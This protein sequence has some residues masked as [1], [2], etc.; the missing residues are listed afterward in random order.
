M[1]MRT[2]RICI[3]E[4]NLPSTSGPQSIALAAL[5]SAAVAQGHRVITLIAGDSETVRHYDGEEP[6]D[7]P[8]SETTLA[9]PAISG[10]RTMRASYRTYQWLSERHFDLIFAGAHQSPL[11]YSLL[12]KRQGTDFRT[13]AF[14]TVVT[15]LTAAELSSEGRFLDGIEHLIADEIERAVIER[16]DAVI[17]ADAD[18][19]DWIRGQDWPRPATFLRA[20][21]AGDS[22]EAAQEWSEL[23]RR[24]IAGV[25]EHSDEHGDPIATRDRKPLVSACIVSFNRHRLLS[26]AIQSI[27]D[28]TY[29]N[30]EIIVVDDASDAPE[31]AIQLDRIAVE[32]EGCGGRLIRHERNRYLGAARN[33][34]ARHATGEY[35]F[36]LDDD[37]IAKPDQI[38]TLVDVA[39]FTNCDIVNSFC[40]RHFGEDRPAPD[41]GSPERWIMLGNVPSVGLFHNLFGPASA[42]IKTASFTRLGGFSEAHGVGH[43]DWE[44][45]AKASLAG[46]N[47]QLVPRALFWYRHTPG[48]MIQTIDPHQ[49]MARNISAY[50]HHIPKPLHPACVLAIGLDRRQGA[51]QHELSGSRE[52]LAATRDEVARLQQRVSLLEQENRD[53]LAACRTALGAPATST[54]QSA[55]DQYWESRSW[56]LGRILRI[57]RGISLRNRQPE[58]R[59]VIRSWIEAAMTI[60]AIRGTISWEV[61]GSARAIRRAIHR[62]VRPGTSGHGRSAAPRLRQGGIDPTIRAPATEESA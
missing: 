53:L 3:I 30:I 18:V 20:P 21:V 38:A 61:L 2:L 34:A 11:Y 24:I 6:G 22:D 16:S 45:F 55:L 12:A 28:Q 59:P 15:A 56:R 19:D 60:S 5:R 50:L 39:T 62:P 13:T 33:T 31:S 49:S 10:T 51:M 7:P 9:V 47:L 35:L 43:E 42:L 17:A 23:F 1:I 54:P 25:V 46:M 57:I 8:L 36:F 27:Q 29:P 14:C 40:D 26:Q 58:V 41:Q 4:D 48:S 44:F 32:L 37:D 52:Q